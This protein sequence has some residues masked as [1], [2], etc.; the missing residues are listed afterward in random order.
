MWLRM[1]FHPKQRLDTIS[2][3]ARVSENNQ[4]YVGILKLKCYVINKIVMYCMLCKPFC[5]LIFNW[6][7]VYIVFLKKNYVY[8]SCWTEWCIASKAWPAKVGLGMLLEIQMELKNNPRLVQLLIVSCVLS[9]SVV[10]ILLQ[11]SAALRV[12]IDFGSAAYFS[13]SLLLY[14]A[15]IN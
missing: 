5:E 7:A 13:L 8:A 3:T 14:K 2:K 11:V 10:H 9:F 6:K 12:L 1:G 15:C 4:L